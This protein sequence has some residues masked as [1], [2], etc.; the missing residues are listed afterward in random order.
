M[1]HLVDAKLQSPA[2]G[3]GSSCGIRRDFDADCL[4]MAG[5][6]E[7]FLERWARFAVRRGWFVIAAVMALTAIPASQIPNIR[8]DSSTQ[9]YFHPDDPTLIR[10]NEF[11]EEF[12]YD[13]LVVISI[14]P[15]NVFDIAFLERLTAFHR[16][17]EERV[18][19]IEE[20]TSLVNARHT[21]GD[22]DGLIV[23]DLMQ[24]LP[25]NTA[26]LDLLRGRIEHN[27]VYTNTLISEDARFT[28]LTVKPNAY[29]DAYLSVVELDGL[30]ASDEATPAVYRTEAENYAMLDAIHEVISEFE[31]DAFPIGIA[32]GPAL[33]GRINRSVQT[34]VANF[35]GY[36]ILAIML[37]LFVLFR[38]A[39]GVFL[40]VMVV[41]LSA[42]S[43]LGIM[44]ILDI[45]MSIVTQI[46]PSFILAVGICDSVH[47]LTIV[48]QRL[49]MGDARE[50]AIVF[51]LSHSG[52]AIFMTSL[53]TAAGLISFTSAELLPVTQLGI[54]A[55]IG[56]M[57]ALVYTVVLLPALLAVI[58][59]SGN[60]RFFQRI[61]PSLMDAMLVMFSNVATQRPKTVVLGSAVLL[62]IAG[63]G[64]SQLRIA[65][66]EL[67]WLPEGD[68]L[69]ESMLEMNDT[70]KGSM[71]FELLID[72]E[73]ENGVHNP[74][75]LKQ[76]DE[77]TATNQQLDQDGIFIGKNL[78]VVDVVKESHRALNENQETFYAVPD[79]RKVVAQELLLFEQSG[80][81]DLDDFVD[82]ELSVARITLKIPWVDSTY[83]GP[84]FDRI[85]AH[86]R[87][88]VGDDMK[89]TATGL[90]SLMGR[91]MRLVLKSLVRSYMIALMIITPMMILLIGSWRRG[92]LSMIPNL[93]PVIMTLGV[94]GLIGFPIDMSSLLVGSIIIG[95]AVDD[96]IHFMHRFTR[97][98][99]NTGDAVFAVRETLTTTGAALLF[100]SLVLSAGFLVFTMA[101]MRN[102][103]IFGFLSTFAV[104]MAFLADVLLA[105]AL[106]ILVSKPQPARHE[107]AIG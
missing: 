20:V 41:C 33:E 63:V 35:V 61:G 103:A 88:I 96:T 4:P 26:E 17:L 107:E 93:L 104:L 76:I 90:G 8:F 3:R 101:Y 80:S 65:Q 98:Y 22:A 87:S 6:L 83:Y 106:M 54:T 11:R 50:D 95:I 9:S 2:F 19:H 44:A 78:S 92:L 66:N 27:P 67:L 68:P 12:G 105:P 14:A 69:R 43:T 100:T 60:P 55:P 34:D 5:Q 24:V 48:F 38:R 21:R 45:P 58:P 99:K 82:T 51:S 16:A 29:S 13:E 97:Y 49:R 81:D 84:F 32:G 36:S 47:I 42:V 53:T 70:L 71:T 15:E 23:E 94:M 89:F 62:A 31:N 18:P 102:I 30:A 73:T 75:L 1:R 7:R 74:E 79:D 25:S 39:S 37:L 57:L 91:M 52:M 86:L 46:V 72:T 85:E 10:Y 59:I 28:A 40:P 64:V 56:V 77:F